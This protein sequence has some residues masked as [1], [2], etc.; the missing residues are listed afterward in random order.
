MTDE[1]EKRRLVS[2]DLTKRNETLILKLKI[3]I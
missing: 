3:Q 2:V 1:D